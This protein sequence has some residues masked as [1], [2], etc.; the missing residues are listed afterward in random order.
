ME[1]SK[2]ITFIYTDSSGGYDCYMLER[3]DEFLGYL[4]LKDELQLTPAS[5]I[6]KDAETIINQVVW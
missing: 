1:R 3:D 5:L 2:K 6:L 4:Y